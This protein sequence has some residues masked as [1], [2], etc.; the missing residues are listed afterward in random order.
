M[1]Y[2]FYV[3][4]LMSIFSFDYVSIQAKE[5]HQEFLK[6]NLS[7]GPYL[8]SYPQAQKVTNTLNLLAIGKSFATGIK[9][10]P[11]G[12]DLVQPHIHK[13]QDVLMFTGEQRT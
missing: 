9:K 10:D 4:D 13:I 5:S 1:E 7:N 8:V 11:V 3:H 12:T 2:G 6:D